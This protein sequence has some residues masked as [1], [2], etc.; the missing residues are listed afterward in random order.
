[1]TLSGTNQDDLLPLYQLA[2]EKGWEFATAAAHNSFYFHKQDNVI[3]DGVG[4]ASALDGLVGCMLAE[5][6]PKSWARAYF[7]AGLKGYVL[8]RP[9]PLPCRAGSSNFFIDPAANVLPCNG[10]AE[11]MRMGN[12]AEASSF[13]EIWESD[14]AREVRA[15]VAACTRNCWMMGTASPAI[16]SHPLQVGAWILKEQCGRVF[17]SDAKKEGSE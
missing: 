2:R 11:A 15:A 7:N 1:M 16:K 3:E 5:N 17:G 4:V 10:M 9:R 6:S 13:E 8:G 14:R 12:L